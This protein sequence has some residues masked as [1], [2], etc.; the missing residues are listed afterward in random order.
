MFMVMIYIRRAIMR[1]MKLIVAVVL[2]FSL[3]LAYALTTTNVSEMAAKVVKVNAM[4]INNTLTHHGK[5][6]VFMD[7]QNTGNV[8]HTLI[9]VTSPIAQQAQLHQSMEHIKTP[10]PMQQLYNIKIPPH[11]DEDLHYGGPHI[12]LL[13]IKKPIESHDE[14]PITLIFSD[15]SWLTIDA[16][17]FTAPKTL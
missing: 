4:R 13:G 2:L 3:Q 17:V 7:L 11:Q 9:A 6:E 5:T 12:M 8:P 10:I 1:L 15:G 14:I 16:K